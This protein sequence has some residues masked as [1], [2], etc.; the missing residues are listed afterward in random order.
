MLWVLIDSTVNQVFVTINSSIK[1]VDSSILYWVFVFAGLIMSIA[2][3]EFAHAWS[4]Y[5][6]GDETA[7]YEDR[8][9]INP[10]KHFDALGLG[11][12]LFTFIGYGKP[13]PVNP[14]NFDNPK[15]GMMLVALAGPSSNLILS[16][17][18]GILFVAFKPF[19]V[20]GDLNSIGG[21]INGIISTLVYA[22]PRIGAINISLMVFNML[23]FIPL[24]GSKIWGYIHWKVEEFLNTYVFPYS[25]ILIIVTILP[26]LGGISIFGILSSV[27]II[28]YRLV[29]NL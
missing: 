21:I 17:V 18:L 1:N 20:S 29:F 6:L 12:I 5:K 28:A 27:F 7:K 9:N 4:A 3:H 15:K 14:N 10:L 2:I 25:I 23:P 26:I 13:V 11:L 8:L 16:I 22:L 24:D 19:V